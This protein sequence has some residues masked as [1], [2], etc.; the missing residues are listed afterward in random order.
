VQVFA[1]VLFESLLHAK[2]RRIFGYEWDVKG[3]VIEKKEL[4]ITYFITKMYGD[5]EQLCSCPLVNLNSVISTV[6]NKRR[7]SKNRS[8]FN[9]YE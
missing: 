8:H 2:L 4:T 9:V 6:F 3:F 1:Q 5:L 7:V